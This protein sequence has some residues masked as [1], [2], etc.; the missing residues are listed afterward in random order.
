M[1]TQLT[2]KK[3]TVNNMRLL[4]AKQIAEYLGNNISRDKI[5]KLMKANVFK[6]IWLN[7]KLVSD[8][9]S[10]R[11]FADSLFDSEIK[12]I[13]EVTPVCRRGLKKSPVKL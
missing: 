6:T 9:L 7:G 3:V 1:S 12:G 10:V 11:Q 13:I 4:N 2:H 5:Y 8:A